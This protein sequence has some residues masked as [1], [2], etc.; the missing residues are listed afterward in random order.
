MIFEG[1][2]KAV[3]ELASFHRFKEIHLSL[4]DQITETIAIVLNTIEANMRTESLLKQSQSLAGELTTQQDELRE[5]NTRLEKQAATLQASEELLKQQQDELKRANEELETKAG[6]L[7]TQKT[8][9]EGKN[10]EIEL[11]KLALQEKAEQLELTSKYKSEFL[12]NMSHELRTPLNSLLI[13]SEMLADNAEG[14]LTPKQQE[15]AQTIYAAGSDLLSLIN[16]ILD[17]AKIESGTMAI[18]VGEYSFADL[19]EYVERTFRPMA[20]TK[21]LALGV[22]LAAGLPRCHL[23][24]LQA[25]A[26]GAAE[27]ALQ[28]LQ[29]HRDGS[30]RPAGRA[31]RRRLVGRPPGAQPRRPRR[32]LL[33]QRHRHRHRR[34]QAEDHLRAVPAGRHGDRPHVR[35]DGPGAVDQPGDRPP[36]RRRDPGPEHARR[37][38][39]LHPVPAAG[40]RASG[41]PSPAPS[42]GEAGSAGIRRGAPLD[43]RH[44][45]RRRAALPTRRPSRRW[46]SAATATTSS[47]ATGSS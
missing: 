46:T 31:G 24:R 41:P 42:P 26:A 28:R 33:R 47:R 8:Q 6:Q 34:G 4:L 14:N 38:E 44:Q 29:V 7:S 25:A 13:L 1:E 39:H 22:E 10:R 23:H 45:W 21:G 19:R 11:A 30:G 43:P 35:R 9:V 18:E 40:L 3:I 20:E 27:P 16:D 12:A 32:G 36:A 37:G 5:T 17:M 2:V 15:F